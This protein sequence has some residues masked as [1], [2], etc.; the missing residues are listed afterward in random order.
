[1]ITFFELLFLVVVLSAV[2]CFVVCGFFA[3]EII[4]LCQ[5]KTEEIKARA[6]IIKDCNTKLKEESVHDKD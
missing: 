2:V 6:A 3:D 5:A 1:M 4:A